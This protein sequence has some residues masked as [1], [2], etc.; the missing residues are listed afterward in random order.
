M[1]D[2]WLLIYVLCLCSFV[3][4]AFKTSIIEEAVADIDVYIKVAWCTFMVAASC[5]QES[6]TI[7]VI[8]NNEV[9]DEIHIGGK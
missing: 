8:R 7:T 3:W 1:F 5:G 2:F 4:M 9:V 6:Y